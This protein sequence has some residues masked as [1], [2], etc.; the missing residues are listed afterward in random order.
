M[1]PWLRTTGAVALLAGGAL[2][3]RLALDAYGTDDLITVFF[4]NAIGSALVGAWVVY[5]RRPL[6]LTAGIGISAVS[7]AAFGL[8]RVGDGVLGFRGVGVEPA[9]DVVLTL[10][11]EGVALV[12]LGAALFASRRDLVAYSRRL[13][14]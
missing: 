6:S 8:S 13:R 3:V 10:A 12:L 7:L 4:M 5:D 1:N 14:G 2:H 9:P 11:A